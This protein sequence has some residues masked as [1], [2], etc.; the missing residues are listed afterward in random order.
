MLAFS[1]L[2]A[3]F[4][5]DTDCHLL[6]CLFVSCF[7][8]QDN[9]AL[10]KELRKR[11]KN[12]CAKRVT[13]RVERYKNRLKEQLPSQITIWDA[14]EERL[15]KILSGITGVPI[16]ALLVRQ[17]PDPPVEADPDTDDESKTNHEED[18]CISNETEVSNKIC[19]LY[20]SPSPRD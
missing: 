9:Q 8:M 17:C 15:L 7:F 4:G 2:F 12:A 1:R 16:A 18:E 19:L 11:A 5:R 6:A 13:K 3:C 10:L 20:T 14:R